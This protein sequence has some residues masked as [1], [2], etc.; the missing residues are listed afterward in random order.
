MS[1]RPETLEN[2]ERALD[3]STRR[4]APDAK[5]GSQ[6]EGS[7]AAELRAVRERIEAAHAIKPQGAELH[8]ADCWRRGRDAALRLIEGEGG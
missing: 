1:V 5:Q 4:P 3:L 6:R 8:C 2:P 7:S